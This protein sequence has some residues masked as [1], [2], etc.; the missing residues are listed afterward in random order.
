MADQIPEGHLNVINR[1]D[2][3]TDNLPG[4]SVIVCCYN[5]VN[6]LPE[7]LAHL[8]GRTYRVA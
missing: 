7:T 5:S 6:R 4:I 2:H 8:A 3:K 1:T